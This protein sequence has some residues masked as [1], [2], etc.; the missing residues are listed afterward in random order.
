MDNSG[1]DSLIPHTSGDIVETPPNP[2]SEGADE[3]YRTLGSSLNRRV[4]PTSKQHILSGEDN[5][6]LVIPCTQANSGATVHFTTGDNKHMSQGPRTHI[7]QGNDTL[8]GTLLTVV[9]GGDRP[10]AVQEENL[11]KIQAEGGYVRG[12]PLDSAQG[13]ITQFMGVADWVDRGLSAG[14]DEEVIPKPESDTL[15]NIPLSLST[16]RNRSHL[17]HV[18]RLAPVRGGEKTV[19]THSIV[20]PD[21][22]MQEIS[23]GQKLSGNAFRRVTYV[24][25][26][27]EDPQDTGS[28]WVNGRLFPGSEHTSTQRT[29]YLSDTQGVTLAHY[30]QGDRRSQEFR[31]QGIVAMDHNPEEPEPMYFIQTH[32]STQGSSPLQLIPVYSQG[33]NHV[34]GSSH[35]SNQTNLGNDTQMHTTLTSTHGRGIYANKY[36]YHST[37]MRDPPASQGT[38]RI[39]GD[40]DNICIDG[41]VSRM[42]IGNGRSHAYQAIGGYDG[43]MMGHERSN[44]T[45]HFEQDRAT[46]HQVTDNVA[47]L[48]KTPTFMDKQRYNEYDMIDSNKA[49]DP[50][51]SRTDQRTQEGVYMRGREYVPDNLHQNTPHNNQPTKCTDSPVAYRNQ[52]SLGQSVPYANLYSNTPTN[53]YQSPDYNY[54]ME[55]RGRTQTPTFHNKNKKI[56]SYDGSTNWN[57]YLVQFEMVSKLNGWDELTKAMELATSLKGPALAVMVDLD[58]SL[59]NNYREL[60]SAL[61]N[62]F[63]STTSTELF[64][65]QMKTRVRKRSESLAEL[66]QHIKRL[67]RQ[68]Y[69]LHPSSIREPLA[70]DCFVDALSDYD[71]RWSIYQS[72]PKTVD[73]ALR[74][75]AEYEGFKMAADRRGQNKGTNSRH[76]NDNYVFALGKDSTNRKALD[77]NYPNK[78]RGCRNWRGDD[79]T[80]PECPYGTIC[81]NCGEE[82]H[83]KKDCTQRR[84]QAQS[85]K[86]NA[87]S[88]NNEEN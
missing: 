49:F 13:N 20:V 60:V 40:M 44:I 35:R 26:P 78:Q 8:N 5:S 34:M 69:P 64:R 58:P 67:V 73:E 85:K 18:G 79:H 61:D 71:M 36:A 32:K 65:V 68:A 83:M 10:S 43:G 21:G 16:Q 22:S 29:T 59:R 48:D 25:H 19:T 6:S 53:Q 24:E 47:S 84:R 52:D 7:I 1:Q 30:N 23:S 41:N 75:A 38:N 70:L 12:V 42:T 72:K 81:F 11:H 88:T 87:A 4:L 17:S 66:A 15:S 33:R 39:I 80:W 56:S 82:G 27:V 50:R 77:G 76:A 37:P 55:T 2:N 14:F 28:R 3:G 9:S 62:R 54:T 31:Q 74:L 57:D 45:T 51:F 86:Q 63:E 46:L